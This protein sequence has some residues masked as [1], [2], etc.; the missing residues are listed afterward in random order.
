MLFDTLT[1][2]GGWARAHPQQGHRQHKPEEQRHS[3]AVL[4][5]RGTG[6]GWRTGL[7]K[8]LW[9]S[10]RVN[11]KSCIWG[12]I[13]Q[14]SQA[15][16]EGWK[17]VLCRIWEPWGTGAEQ[18][19]APPPPW[20]SKPRAAWALQEQHCQQVT[21]NSAAQRDWG[22][23][24]CAD[25]Q[26]LT[27]NGPEKAV[28]DDLPGA[29]GKTA[30]PLQNMVLAWWQCLAAAIVTMELLVLNHFCSSANL[31]TWKLFPFY[32]DCYSLVPLQVFSEPFSAVLTVPRPGPWWHVAPPAL[33]PSSCSS[34]SPASEL[35]NA[36]SLHPAGSSGICKGQQ[37]L[38]RTL[39]TLPA[40]YSILQE[41]Q[42][43][44]TTDDIQK[45]H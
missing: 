40:N 32:T 31:A 37:P 7:R 11:A 26:S 12:E 5:P 4:P 10:T 17:T 9:S 42:R 20:Q 18:E 45:F 23:S 34:P 41:S 3:K 16:L 27:G 39:H 13:A 43:S 30:A 15:M 44:D 8:C 14:D 21:A 29:V 36:P 25:I 33:P 28:P 2:P 35:Q 38:F 22:V 6:T 19:P 24:I 1:S